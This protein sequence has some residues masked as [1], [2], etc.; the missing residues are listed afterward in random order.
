[1]PWMKGTIRWLASESLHY[2][3][4]FLPFDDGPKGSFQSLSRLSKC[5]SLSLLAPKADA[6][7]E[8]CARVEPNSHL[9]IYSVL[10]YVDHRTINAKRQPDAV[11]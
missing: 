11:D 8:I 3:H 7:L 10:E 5:F 1:M 4:G 2:P 6:N 9:T